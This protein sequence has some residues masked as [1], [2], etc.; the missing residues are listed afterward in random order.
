[1]NRI[2]NPIAVLTVFIGLLISSCANKHSLREQ[3][4]QITKNA[5]GTIG[6]AIKNLATND[7]LTINN[8]LQFP[9]QSV[10]KFPLA[11]AVLKQIDDGIFSLNQPFRIDKT[12]LLPN[13][14]SPLREKYPDGNVI[15][16]LSEIISY[17]VSQSDN[18][19]CDILF[20]LLGGPS[21][22]NNYIHS[23]GVSEISIMGT[24][25]EMH[26]DWN[27]QF[28]NWCKPYA[29][30]QILDIFYQ[31]KGLSD[32]STNFLWERMVE[33][34]TGPNR[35]K[36]LLPKETIIAHK[37]G[38]SGKNEDGLTAAINDVGIIELPNG[39]RIAISIFVSNATV[40]DSISERVIAE[41]AK[42]TYDF[43]LNIK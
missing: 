30:V 15:I 27:V 3:I 9:M 43:Y 8:N 17:T 21:F 2:F 22:V 24:E 11:I 32:S 40:D 12:D 34:T 19:G 7:T 6:V 20:R 13:T 28:T 23:I 18:N 36:G 39:Q 10:Y 38:Y 1:M 5:D 33:T 41:I 31:K 37:T 42:A 14:W 16:P 35:I 4:Q 26:K 25:E 29:M